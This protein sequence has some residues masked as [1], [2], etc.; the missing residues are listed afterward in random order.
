MASGKRYVVL[1]FATL[2]NFFHSALLFGWPSIVYV[3]K[4]MGY[5]SDL[6]PV[7]ES[8]NTTN[9][10]TS[11]LTT[12]ETVTLLDLTTVTEGSGGTSITCDEQD[13]SL[14]LIYTVAST[15]LP[16]SMIFGGILFEKYGTL[17]TRL[18]FR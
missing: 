3:F 13:A 12:G 5:Y 9:T 6:C 2:E 18:S 14:L 1:V 15:L 11:P 17:V 16:I 7:E 10:T 8:D 4:D